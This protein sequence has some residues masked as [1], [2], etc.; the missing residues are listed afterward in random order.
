MV[1]GVTLNQIRRAR[2]GI[3]AQM[4]TKEG[5]MVMDILVAENEKS[6]HVFNAVS[7]GMT[8]SLAVAEFLVVKSLEKT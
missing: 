2:S 8:C 4:I 7:P 5:S 6:L 1:E 3:R